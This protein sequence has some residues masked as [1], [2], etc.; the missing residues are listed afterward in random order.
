VIPGCAPTRSKEEARRMAGFFFSRLPLVSSQ[1]RFRLTRVAWGALRVASIS[2]GDVQ[3]ARLPRPRAHVRREIDLVIGT[4]K[5]ARAI[6]M[7][8]IAAPLG[9]SPCA[10]PKDEHLNMPCLHW[11]VGVHTSTA[12]HDALFADAH[13]R[14]T[15][16]ELKAGI[17]THIRKRHARS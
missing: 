3:S 1:P 6:R 13:P 4:R 17:A 7:I 12:I 9:V 11:C 15:L 16:K 14:K 2:I 5:P 8:L 10:S